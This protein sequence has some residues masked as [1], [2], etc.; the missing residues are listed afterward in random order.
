MRTA[1]G[2][3]D[4]VGVGVHRL[5]VRAGPL[6]GDL[7]RDPALD[8]LGLE[9]DDLRVHQL[10]LLGLVEV[11]DVVDQPAVVAVAHGP[12][13]RAAVRA[14]RAGDGDLV[15]GAD[16]LGPLVDQD[17]L[18][19]LVEEGH[20]LEPR[21]QGLE[22]EVDGLEDVLVGP[23]GHRRAVGAVARRLGERGLGDAVTVVLGVELAVEPD[24]DL[25][26]VG[27]GVDHR[28]PDPVQAARDGVP[29]P[30]EL[31]AGVQHGEDD[32]D[33]RLALGL[34]DPDRDAA[35]V[36]HDLH[37]AVGAQ[38]HDDAVA[39][40]RQGLVDGV[41]DHLVH[42]VVQPARA[43]GPDVHAGTLA[44]GL[45]PF[46]DGDG[47]GVV[48]VVSLGRSV[49]S[50]L[51]SHGRRCSS[52][53]GGP[54]GRVQEHTRGRGIRGRRGRTGGRRDRPAGPRPRECPDVPPE[55]TC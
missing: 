41:V 29:A 53:C 38:R 3:G 25:Q 1:L 46:E 23:E 51:V 43:G 49:A 4:G 16:V 6:Q 31:A 12:L 33:G 13:L 34:H 44:H 39:V 50:R 37:S 54:G 26:P 40:A 55:S 48:A 27:E 15:L 32:L 8:V 35:A 2:R 11:G 7:D 42:Q 45:E 52:R 9:V 19:T 47:A 24:L 30:A 10:G 18:Q 28:D 5:G 17:D 14:V 22:V 21:P 20:L 36:V